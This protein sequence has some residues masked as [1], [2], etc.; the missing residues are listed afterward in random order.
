[1]TDNEAFATLQSAMHDYASARKSL[2]LHRGLAK[3]GIANELAYAVAA[4]HS[5]LH[6]LDRAQKAYA[7]FQPAPSAKPVVAATPATAAIKVATVS[8]TVIAKPVSIATPSYAE[9]KRD[10]DFARDAYQAAV[11]RQDA[12][13]KAAVAAS[14]ARHTAKHS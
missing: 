6:R 1:M 11:R 3:H 8:Q 10:A 2:D 12:A 4:E 14:Q 5:A 13:H 9:A 7:A